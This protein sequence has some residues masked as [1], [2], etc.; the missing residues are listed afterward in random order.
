MCER[1]W[2]KV[3]IDFIR[4]HR[5][6]DVATKFPGADLPFGTRDPRE[7]DQTTCGAPSAD[8]HLGHAPA[9]VLNAV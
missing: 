1:E 7:L 4:N 5:A 8:Q 9:Q 3:F 6:V 2:R